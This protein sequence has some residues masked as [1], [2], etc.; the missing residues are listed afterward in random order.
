MGTYYRSMIGQID[1]RLIPGLKPP[2][3]YVFKAKLIE[4]SPDEFEKAYTYFRN[5]RNKHLH[6][7]DVPSKGHPRYVVTNACQSLS[8]AM[9][10]GTINSLVTLNTIL[11]N[12]IE[13]LCYATDRSVGILYSTLVDTYVNM[14]FV[15]QDENPTHTPVYS[16]RGIFSQTVDEPVLEACSTLFRT[17]DILAIIRESLITHLTT[18]GQPVT[19][20]YDVRYLSSVCKRKIDDTT[21]LT[22]MKHM[23]SIME[24]GTK[25]SID[26]GHVPPVSLLFPPQPI[27]WLVENDYMGGPPDLDAMAKIKT[28]RLEAQ[29]EKVRLERVALDNRII[30]GDEA[31]KATVEATDHRAVLVA[32]AEADAL[33]DPNVEKIPPVSDEWSIDHIPAALN[34][35]WRFSAQEETHWLM[36]VIE[37]RFGG[38]EEITNPPLNNYKP[39]IVTPPA[40]NPA[41]LEKIPTSIRAMFAVTTY[42]Y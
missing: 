25:R 23:M 29:E 36:K 10:S 24:I 11:G 9:V 7:Y 31:A 13:F 26:M 17:F 3:E 32:K 38:T 20:L 12:M 18:A 30:N 33:G 42:D 35:V 5:L 39:H 34:G 37:A 2:Q 8:L 14:E 4:I 16:L 15:D 21:L 6:T 41:D 28:D 19:S 40:P 1:H 22:M 27:D